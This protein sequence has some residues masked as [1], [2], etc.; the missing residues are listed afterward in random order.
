MKN[1][2]K[3]DYFSKHYSKDGSASNG[4]D[5]GWVSEGDMAQALKQ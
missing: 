4:G 1:C 2:V 5:L 3:G